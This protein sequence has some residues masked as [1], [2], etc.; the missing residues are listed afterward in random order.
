MTD[1]TIGFKVSF[2]EKERLKALAEQNNLK[3]SDYI[4]QELLDENNKACRLHQAIAL[5]LLYNGCS[6]EVASIEEIN[7]IIDVFEEAM[8]NLNSQQ[9]SLLNQLISILSEAKLEI[10]RIGE[11]PFTLDGL[12]H[13]LWLNFLNPAVQE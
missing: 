7:F 11:Y 10:E 6:L 1:Q 13:D 3:L 4:R 5:L 8:S 12:S 2:E 9:S